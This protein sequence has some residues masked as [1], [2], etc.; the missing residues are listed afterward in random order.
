VRRNAR[1]RKERAEKKAQRIIARMPPKVEPTDDWATAARKMQRL[2]AWVRSVQREVGDDREL[3][4]R[5]EALLKERLGL[6]PNTVGE[7]PPAE[8]QRSLLTAGVT[9]HT[10]PTPAAIE[11]MR[12]VGIEPDRLAERY[13]E[14]W[15]ERGQEM[16]V[17]YQIGDEMLCV[18]RRS[19]ELRIDVWVRGELGQD[20]P[21]P[22]AVFRAGDFN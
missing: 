11:L 13:V 5:V 6:P 20:E 10:D 4:E 14:L 17:L 12:A 9:P 19:G 8:V 15:R 22:Q 18:G 1:R 2:D 16:V 21:E 7:E 3:L